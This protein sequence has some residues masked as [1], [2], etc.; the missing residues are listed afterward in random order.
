MATAAGNS[1]RLSVLDATPEA[2]QREA[3]E[4]EKDRLAA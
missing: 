4:L 2:S 1:R 3:R